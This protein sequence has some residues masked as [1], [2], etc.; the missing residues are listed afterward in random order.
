MTRRVARERHTAG[1]ATLETIAYLPYV[2]MMFLMAI[3]V[4]AYMATIEEVDSAA[5]AGARVT[6]QGGNGR[7]AAYD[8]LPSRLH[9]QHTV[10]H[11]VATGGGAA[12]ATVTARVPLI[13]NAPIDWSVTRTVSMPIG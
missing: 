9:N 11:I 5:R 2:L 8:A 10:I 7:A 6:S 13:F 12:N 4:F 3:E 1:Q